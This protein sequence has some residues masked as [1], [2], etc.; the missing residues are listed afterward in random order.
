MKSNKK[1]LKSSQNPFHWKHYESEIILL[2]VRWYCSYGLS[3]RNLA[4]MMEER[5]MNLHHTTIMRWVHEYAPQIDK[6]IRPHLKRTDK[7]WRVDETYIKVKGKWTYLYRA[8]D[9][10]GNTLDFLLR[11]KRDA[12][13]ASRFFR[14]V[15]K[16]NH[17]Q[18]PQV[19]NIDKNPALSCSLEQL[20]SEGVL[21]EQMEIRPV[22]YLNNIVEQDH[23]FIKKVT[24][25]CLGFQSVR[26]ASKTISGIEAMHMLWKGQLQRSFSAG[27]SRAQI[28][29]K[30]FGLAA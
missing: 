20:K 22:K 17:T 10:N 19:I 24:K 11:A 27:L 9:K 16:A 23:R 21:T 14:K 4:E 2:N 26:T 15:L 13:A 12:K 18:T 30:L 1:S 7:S 28:V 5:G 29:N 25:P 8:V 3:Y 6:K